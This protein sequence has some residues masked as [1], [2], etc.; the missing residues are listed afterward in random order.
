[1]AGAYMTVVN[2][3]RDVE[4]LVGGSI[5][6]VSRFELHRMVMD[7]NIAKMRPVEGGLE[8][9]PDQSVVLTPDSFH[10]MLI[11]FKQPFQQGQHIKGTLEF[12]RAGKVE[13]EFTVEGIGAK[14]PG[15]SMP[16]NHTGH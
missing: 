1:M 10:V 8:I 5:A 14:A 2:K 16:M 12:Q 9:K 7:G 3:G 6:G 11:G 13:V 15:E 4:R